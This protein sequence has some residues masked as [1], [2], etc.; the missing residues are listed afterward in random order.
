MVDSISVDH[1]NNNVEFINLCKAKTSTVKNGSNPHHG[2]FG[3]CFSFGLRNEDIV[4]TG[5]P[6]SKKGRKVL[7]VNKLPFSPQVKPPQINK[8]F[9]IGAPL[10]VSLTKLLLE[11][12]ENCKKLGKH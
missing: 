5:S 8:V 3:H 12:L 9:V 1:W 6:M 10:G 2:Y 7:S 4:Q 11:Y